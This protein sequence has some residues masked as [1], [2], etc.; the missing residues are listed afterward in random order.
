MDK[1]N[2]LRGYA[3]AAE[4]A[5]HLY[6]KVHGKDAKIVGDDNLFNGA[7]RVVDGINIQSKYCKSGLKCIEECFKDGRFRYMNADGSPMQIE[8]PSDKYDAAVQAMENKIKNSQMP[9]VTDPKDAKNIVRK[10]YLVP[11]QEGDLQ[12]K[13]LM[14]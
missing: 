9:G 11:L 7:D 5:N 4:R 10:A 14:L 8:V 3:F 13:H 1:F 2:T 12:E 6:D